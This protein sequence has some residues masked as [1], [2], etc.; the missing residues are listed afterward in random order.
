[1]CPILVD[2]WLVDDSALAFA[3][4]LHSYLTTFAVVEKQN[5]VAFLRVEG[6]YILVDVCPHSERK[7]HTFKPF[8]SHPIMRLPPNLPVLPTYSD[9]F[10]GGQSLIFRCCSLAR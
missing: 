2:W 1:M 3:E 7:P 6:Y 4:S 9:L 10:L 8:A 5:G